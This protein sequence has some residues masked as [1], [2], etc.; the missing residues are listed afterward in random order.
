MASERTEKLAKT[1]H[2]EEL[3]RIRD[4][5]RG[6]RKTAVSVVR[7]SERPQEKN[8]QGLMRW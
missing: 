1:T 3:F 5:Q 8:R 2:W 7:K 4:Q 6:F